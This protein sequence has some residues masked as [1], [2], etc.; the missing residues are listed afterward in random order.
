MK[1]RLFGD[2]IAEL[3]RN[4]DG[5]SG[6]LEHAQGTLTMVRGALAK[7]AAALKKAREAEEKLRLELREAC[8]RVSHTH[9]TVAQ[10]ERE[11][12]ETLRGQVAKLRERLEISPFGDDKIDELS[13]AVNVLRCRVE[14]TERER[15]AARAELAALREERG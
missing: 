8:A 13:S 10:A 5:L 4:V 3:A 15:D 7:Q 6:E 1:I 12:L 14:G 9:A 2:M 11:E